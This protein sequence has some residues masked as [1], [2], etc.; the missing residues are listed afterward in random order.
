[1]P[2][3]ITLNESQKLYVIP[4][5][6]GYS[7]F[8]FDNAALHTIQMLAQIVSADHAADAP[9]PLELASQ[10]P[11][12]WQD[13]DYGQLSGYEKYTQVLSLWTQSPA[14][15]STYFDPGTDPKVKSILESA[16]KNDQRLRLFLGDTETGRDWMDENDVVGRIGRSMGPMKVPL[17]ISDGE[18]GGGAILTACIVRILDADTLRELYVHPNYQAPVLTVHP[19]SGTPKY[20]FRVDRDDQVHARFKTREQAYG[21]VAFMLGA[22]TRVRSLH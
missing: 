3:Q 12:A 16:R 18:F 20:A 9:G 14:A 21:Y 22:A 11:L 15:R 5:G 1:M 7:C 8:G 13:S 2:S 10:H 19:D 4:C 17:L 6:T